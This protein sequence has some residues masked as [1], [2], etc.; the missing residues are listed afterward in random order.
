ML[1][2]TDIKLTVLTTEV[3]GE[4]HTSNSS[5]LENTTFLQVTKP[6][7]IDMELSSFW[8][9]KSSICSVFGH[10]HYII[11]EFGGEFYN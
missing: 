3:T 9:L 8:S 4:G 11:F 1:D 10:H 7:G 6:K 5:N 2:I